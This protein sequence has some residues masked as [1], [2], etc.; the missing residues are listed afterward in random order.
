MAKYG[1]NVSLGFD[2]FDRAYEPEVMSL[3]SS[4]NACSGDSTSEKA[5]SGKGYSISIDPNKITINDSLINA[6]AAVGNS[7]Y[8]ITNELDEFI[9]RVKALEK[10]VY[11]EKKEEYIRGYTSPAYSYKL[12]IGRVSRIS[13]S[14][15]LTV[16]KGTLEKMNKEQ[17]KKSISEMINYFVGNMVD[18]NLKA[19]AASKEGNETVVHMLQGQAQGLAAGFEQGLDSLLNEVFPEAE[20]EVETEVNEG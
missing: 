1:G 13:R 3:C 17:F 11:G 9:K 15:L 5:Y 10:T 2:A 4:V 19:D 8:T 14:Q 7:S 20:E 12:K 18:F 6:V 16:Q